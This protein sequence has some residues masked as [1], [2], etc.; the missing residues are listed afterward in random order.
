MLARRS[1]TVPSGAPLRYTGQTMRKPGWISRPSSPG[2]LILFETATP[3]VSL[4]LLHRRAAR[5]LGEVVGADRAELGR[6]GRREEDR[7]GVVRPLA[8]RAEGVGGE[9]H[10]LPCSMQLALLAARPPP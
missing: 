2:S 1:S 3:A 7:R 4:R 8:G 9:I 6:R 5:G 10:C